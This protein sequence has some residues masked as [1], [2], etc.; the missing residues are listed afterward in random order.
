MDTHN[1]H[2]ERTPGVPNVRVHFHLA[3]EIAADLDVFA[4]RVGRTRSS[5]IR[6]AIVRL[7]RDYHEIEGD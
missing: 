4:E 1:T 5:A 3:P 7:L 2:T 6:F